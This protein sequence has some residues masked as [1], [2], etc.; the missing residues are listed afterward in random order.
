MRMQRRILA[1]LLVAAG[2]MLAGPA[3]AVTLKIATVAPEGTAWMVEMRRA[4]AA[5]AVRTEG[6]VKLRF[7]PG[8]VMGSEATV[9]RKMRVGQLHGGAFTSSGLSGVYPDIDVYGL[10]FLFR[11]YEEVDYVRARVDERLRAGLENAGLTVL[12]ISETGFAYFMS[13]RPVHDLDE[14]RR[15]KVWAP[16]SDLITRTALEVSGVAPVSLPISDVYTGLQTGLL[17]TVAAPPM[18]AIGLQWH[19]KIKFVAD[20]PVAYVIGILV[21]EPK[22]VR[23]LSPA[24]Q[25]VLREVVATAAAS[26]DQQTRNG[27]REARE[28]LQAQGI[29]LIPPPGPEE[30][31]RWDRVAD[32]TIAR[33]RE[34]GV[35]SGGLIDAIRAY[36][37]EA[38]DGAVARGD[39]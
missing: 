12:A 13:T 33:L 9:L 20:A 2:L 8:G 34:G 32:Q 6:R 19:T 3:S 30:L 36:L 38:R 18:A 7:Y 28:A 29:E 14:L 37:R 5:I 10:P 22:A 27:N 4:A 31:A 39:P 24:D 15:T 1:G 11:S 17:E 25:K 21:L 35:Y 23:R 26:M 16:E